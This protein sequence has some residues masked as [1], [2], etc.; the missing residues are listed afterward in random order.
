MRTTL[1]IAAGLVVLGLGSQ[2]FAAPQEAAFD[3]NKQSVRDVRGGCVLTK[4]EGNNGC[5]GHSTDAEREAR[6]LYFDFNKATLTK[7]SLAKLDAL[8]KTIN[9]SSSITDVSIHGY[10]DQ[11]G[12]DSYNGTLAEKRVAAAKKYLDGKSRL[13]AEGDIRGIGKSSPE[14]GCAALKKRGEKI[15]C[16]A[17]ER[18]VEIEFNANR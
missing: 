4:W 5:A 15:K 9:A 7:E 18:R 12:S 6:T 2:A 17:R 3:K 1:F 10:T 13:K 16:M 11:I 8:A 14:A